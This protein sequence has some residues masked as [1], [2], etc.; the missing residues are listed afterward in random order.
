[1]DDPG[2]KRGDGEEIAGRRERMRAIARAADRI[3]VL[4]LNQEYA[5][6]DVT[7]ERSKFREHVRELYPDRMDLYDMVYEARFDRLM[8]QFRAHDADQGR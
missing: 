7:I 3:S 1:M 2:M 8:E 5:D 6:I 4:I